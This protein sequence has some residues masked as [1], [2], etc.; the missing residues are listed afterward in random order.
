ME[1]A[2]IPSATR[3]VKG[4]EKGAP[5]PG[6]LL[7]GN[8]PITG[9]VAL[10]LTHA[11][12]R[13]YSIFLFHPPAPPGAGGSS[14]RSLLGRMGAAPTPASPTP[15]PGPLHPTPTPAQRAQIYHQIGP[16]PPLTA[17]AGLHLQFDLL[18]CA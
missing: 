16:P 9:S 12:G 18:R 13:R 1:H 5:A 3:V 4:G 11:L 14:A 2:E 17:S 8:G 6:E 15:V 7:Q 10:P